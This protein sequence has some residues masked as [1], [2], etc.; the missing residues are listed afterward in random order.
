MP[1]R[2]AVV[3]AV[4]VLIGTVGAALAWLRL[5][6]T[7]RDTLWAEDGR[8][9]LQGAIDAGFAETFAPYGGYLHVIPRIIA[10]FAAAL[11]V[12]SMAIAMTAGSCLV[13]GG[14]AAVVWLCARRILLPAHAVLLAALTVLAPLA[15]REVLGN[16]ANLHTLMMWTLLWL[17]LVT[18]RRATIA[19]ASAILAALAALT[20]IQAVL[21][22]PVALWR[23]RHPMR[24]IV[25]AGLLAGSSA[26]IIAALLSP[27]R[28]TAFG[29]V[30]PLSYAKGLVVN[31]VLPFLLPQQEIGPVLAGRSLLVVLGAAAVLG[32]LL[33]VLLRSA[34]RSHRILVAL[35][36]AGAVIVY[37]GSV[38]ANP[39]DYY[40]YAG[41][42]AR[43]LRSI[44]LPRYGVLPSMLVA[45]A[46]VVA[47]DGTVRA[48][49]D[50]SGAGRTSALL[51]RI[52]VAALAS[53]LVLHVVPW[54]TRRSQ[55]PAWSPQVEDARRLCA[56]APPRDDVTLKQTLA[57]EV[58]VPCDR[59]RVDSSPAKPRKEDAP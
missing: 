41:H 42:T 43:Q 32:V 29:H 31:A 35:L 7:A 3:A 45:A 50:R 23:V 54:D 49:R 30:E 16:T 52:A 55:G 24:R 33:G 1:P 8:D 59:I 34:S 11:P 51:A 28:Q 39:E 21:L 5:P 20:E 46:V 48:R 36:L 15:A 12:E 37:C 58:T 17:L 22:I 10:G 57:W 19:V 18:P 4:A 25:A 26:Q 44:W 38:Y 27:R 47:A 2:P 6:V 40:D 53:S 9:F 14:C 13:A 56:Q